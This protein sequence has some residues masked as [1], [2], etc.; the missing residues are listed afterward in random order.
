[1][2]C[3]VCGATEFRTE[4][5]S[6]VFIVDSK[7]ILVE[8]IPARVHPVVRRRSAGR[9]PRRCAAWSTVRLGR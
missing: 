5:V 3:N 6:E 8:Q 2:H 7:H 1:M 4:P 9:R